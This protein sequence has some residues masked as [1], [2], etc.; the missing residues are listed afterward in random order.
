MVIQSHKITVEPLKIED[1][2]WFAEVA[3][4]RMLTEEVKRP[5][6]VNLN[7]IYGLSSKGM[8]EGTA[9]VAKS[10]YD[11]VGAIGAVL[12]PNI[13]NPDITTLAEV[14]WWVDPIYR[15]TRAGA[16][17]LKTLEN[18]AN[19]VADEMTLSLLSTSTIN[20][21]TLEKRGFQ[22]GEFAFRKEIRKE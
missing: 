12:T 9:F 5:E 8:K 11:C 19:E 6:L 17:L 22:M 13:F 7:Q 10:G 16:L 20:I 2:L 15:N 14:F 4:V 21:K 3:A 18:R 1:M